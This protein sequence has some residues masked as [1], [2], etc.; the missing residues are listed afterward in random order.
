MKNCKVEEV[1]LNYDE[2]TIVT[3][4]TRKGPYQMS[5]RG[6]RIPKEK[7]SRMVSSIKTKVGAL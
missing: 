2:F 6:H 3:V 7:I 4:D 1:T 5:T